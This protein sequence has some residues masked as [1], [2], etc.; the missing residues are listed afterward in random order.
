MPYGNG[1][2]PAGSASSGA[3]TT[4]SQAITLTAGRLGVACCEWNS[5]SATGSVADNLGNTW[6]PIAGSLATTATGGFSCQI[7]WSI[8]TSGGSATVT[9]TTSSSTTSR[10]LDVLEFTGGP[11]SAPVDASNAANGTST[12][13]SATVTTV[14]DH[15]LVVFHTVVE[16]ASGGN[17]SGWTNALETNDNL[18]AVL[19]EKTPA[20]AATGTSL[21]SNAW[22][23]ASIAAF[24][25][26]AVG[27]GGV[28]EV[29]TPLRVV[30]SSVR[31]GP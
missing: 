4:V 19:L 17:N 18:T 15:D 23:A 12:V 20:G 27:G 5:T 30:R 26:T 9:L 3:G 1:A 7:F 6:T 31:L 29:A 28:V 2:A 22:W 13:S 8:M 11:A 24:S 25:L 14:A 16:S 10:L 21:L